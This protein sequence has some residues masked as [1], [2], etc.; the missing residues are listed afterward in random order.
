MLYRPPENFDFNN[1]RFRRARFARFMKLVEAVNASGNHC[2]IIDVGGVP[3]YW[4]TFHESWKNNNVSIEVLNIVQLHSNHPAIKCVVGDGCSMPEFL[5]GQFDVAHS[6]SVIEHVGSWEN[7]KRMASEISRIAKRYFVQTP[8]IW[9][10]VEP[11][12][13]APIIHWLPEQMRAWIIMRRALG[14]H[15]KASSMD[16]A[17]ASVNDAKLLGRSQLQ[18]LFPNA[19]IQN[20]NLLFFVKSIIAV[21][22]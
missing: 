11:H 18:A 4:E 21:R 1:N 10:P 15:K 17:M 22:D 5:D 8:N 20:E 2:K 6:N 3:E 7:Q 16:E 13:R 9:F 12:F 14:F 19:S